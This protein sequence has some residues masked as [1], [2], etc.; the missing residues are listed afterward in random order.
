VTADGLDAEARA[1]VREALSEQLARVEE[2]VASLT[3]SFDDIVEAATLT[4]TDDEHDPDGSTIAFERAQVASLLR[5]ARQELEA[6]RS[7]VARI[8]DSEFGACEGC[9]GFIGAER[10]VALP[11]TTMCVRCAP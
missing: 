8:D 2:Q 7:A 9:H 10:L 5:D 11:S 6:L 1:L 3:R 4:N